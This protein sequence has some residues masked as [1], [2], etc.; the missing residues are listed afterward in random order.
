MPVETLQ[1]VAVEILR[2]CDELIGEGRFPSSHR[3]AE[4][5]KITRDRARIGLIRD[6]LV[7]TGRLVLPQRPVGG[8]P[9]RGCFAAHPCRWTDAE[10]EA[11]VLAACEIVIAEGRYPSVL[12]LT[13]HLTTTRDQ[14]RLR[15]V[16][17]RLREQG[18]IAFGD[19]EP[20]I[21]EQ[22]AAVVGIGPVPLPD[23]EPPRSRH[24]AIGPFAELIDDALDRQRRRRRWATCC[25]LPQL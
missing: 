19:Y 12:T 22:A 13:P 4:R 18:R 24:A 25:R 23:A 6:L 9:P 5:T 8:A 20:P 2:V 15:E 16:R 7:R 1:P 21:R 3:I 10:V 11:D 17:D 14:R